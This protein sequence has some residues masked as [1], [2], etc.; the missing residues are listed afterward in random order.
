VKIIPP[1][2]NMKSMMN[3]EHIVKVSTQCACSVHQT[4]ARSSSV[5]FQT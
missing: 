4:L 5:S 1:C 2:Q 3:T